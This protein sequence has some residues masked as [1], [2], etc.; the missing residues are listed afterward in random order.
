MNHENKYLQILALHYGYPLTFNKYLSL[1]KTIHSLDNLPTI[2]TIELARIL[3]IPTEKSKI[4]VENYLKMLQVN[5]EDAYKSEGIVPISFDSEKYPMELFE[6]KD[7]PTVI[8]AMGDVSLLEK[9]HKIAIIGSRNATKYSAI[10][11]DYIVPPL[12]ENDFVIVSGLAKGADSLAHRATIQYGGKT[13]GVLGNGFFH[14]YPKE[15]K[16]LSIEMAKNHLLITEYPPY[17]GPKKWQFPMRNR[18][19]SGISEAVVVTEAALRSGTL[20]T[21]DHAL[22]HGK[23]VFVVP[24]PI[25][26]DTSKGTNQLLKEGAI[27]VWNGYQIIEERKMFIGKY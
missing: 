14:Y 22:E 5:L 20:S 26:S 2:S 10:A 11:I 25:D 16:S 13:I 19:I 18:I 12:I 17:V 27:P 4:I 7:P 21:S 23:D 3:Q 1:I 15:N 6:L 8:Y 24:G 9:V